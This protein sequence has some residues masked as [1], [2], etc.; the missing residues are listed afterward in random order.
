MEIIISL[1]YFFAIVLL[2][3]SVGR[4][5]SAKVDAYEKIMVDVPSRQ[6]HGLKKRKRI[7]GNRQRFLKTRVALKQANIPLHAEEYFLVKW[8]FT[9]LISVSIY[10]ITGDFVIASV[11]F[12]MLLIGPR[13]IIKSRISK[14]VKKFDD[15]LN[16]GIVLISNSLKAGYS[17]LQ[18][19]A[20]VAEESTDPLSRVIRALL[21]ELSLGMSMED[22]LENM[23]SRMPSED[24]KLVVNAILIQ[25]DIGGNLSEILENIGET[26]RER[27]KIKNEVKTLTAQGK[28]SGGIVMA[29]PIF[30]GMVIFMFN[31]EYMMILF[32]LLLGRLLLGF[33]LVSQL[34][35][36]LMIRKIIRVDF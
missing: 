24:L 28:L 31:R 3:L 7:L 8:L 25:K 10:M 9:G 1:I 4:G 29:L 13:L 6:G 21:K 27:Q 22:G 17:F 18:A 16:D 33:A 14:E 26:I 20:V 11:A 34:L 15:Q 2:M 30:L 23:V 19:L 32:N 36:W 5:Q 35:G 12:A